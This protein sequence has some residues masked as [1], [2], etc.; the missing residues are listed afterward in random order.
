MK[1][2]INAKGSNME[3]NLNTRLA[4]SFDNDDCY[5][6]EDIS[7]EMGLHTIRTRQ[8]L[9]MAL[10]KHLVQ[11]LQKKDGVRVLYPE[12]MAKKFIALYQDGKLVRPRKSKTARISTKNLHMLIEVPIYDQEVAAVLLNRYETKEGIA[13]V[14]ID[15]VMDIAKPA[16]S[17]LQA[18]EAE[19]AHK[20]KAILANGR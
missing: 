3:K 5:T 20:R 9:K 17:Q 6:I 13:K 8:L 1:I 19:F 16:I 2:L 18:L 11:N 12:P 10:E 4:D 15:T 7:K 14:L